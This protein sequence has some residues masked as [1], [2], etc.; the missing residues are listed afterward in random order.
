MGEN[1]V[2]SSLKRKKP[3]INQGPD[4]PL[5][6]KKA[7]RFS[8]LLI[9]IRWFLALASCI[10]LFCILVTYAPSDPAWSNNSGGLVKNIG[11]RLGAYFADLMLFIFGASAYWWV[12][13]FARGALDWETFWMIFM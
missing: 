7:A 3:L 10:G 1:T 5:L 12:I 9:E 4:S 13:L 2:P 8:E 11:G 6:S